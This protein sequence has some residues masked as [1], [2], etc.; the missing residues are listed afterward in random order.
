MSDQKLILD[1]SFWKF[2]VSLE[3]LQERKEVSLLVSSLGIDEDMLESYCT[4]LNRFNIT[5]SKDAHYI[6]PLKEQ[7]RIKIEFTLSE[8]LALQASM[9]GSE[10]TAYYQQ[11]MQNKLQMAQ[12]AY[13]RFSL[14]KK[15]EDVVV[16]ACH[17]EN[18]KKKIYNVISHKNKVSVRFLANKSCDVFPHRLVYLDGSLC[19][20]GENMM[21]RSLVYFG[22]EDIADVLI[23]ESTYEANLSQI[24]VN[25]F[26]C[27]LRLINGKEER[28]VLKIYSQD[29][30]DLLPE[31][32]YLGNPF[33]TSSTEGDMIWAATIEMC[34]EVFHWLYKMRDRVEVL[35]PGHIRKEFAHFCEM[36]KGNSPSKKAS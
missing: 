33:V 27:H 7:C 24:E 11:I 5:V 15:P 22:V 16:E 34:D 30:A 25:E 23:I 32:H 36:K 31:Y 20:I 19:M 2:L 35:D 9:P 8:W 14:Y 18:L 17:F 6:H 4:F 1:N 12:M 10:A 3:E 29:E 13:A 26:I 28:L 21:D